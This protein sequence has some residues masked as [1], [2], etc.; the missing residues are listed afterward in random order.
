MAT[1]TMRVNDTDATI[2]RKYAKFEG[3]TISDFIRNAVFEKIED[4]EDLETLRTAVA[5]DDGVRY[6]HEQALRELGL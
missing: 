2:V 3:K 5:E 4:Q 1:I 6:A